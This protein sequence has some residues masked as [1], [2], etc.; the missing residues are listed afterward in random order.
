MT[1]NIQVSGKLP[2]GRI[3]V[4]GGDTADL[5]FDNLAGVL[6]DGEKAQR[7]IEDFQ[8]L[9]DPTI[10]QAVANVAPLRTGGAAAPTAA[11]VAAPGAPMCDH[12][13]RVR[14][15]GQGQ[16]GPWVGWFCPTPKGTVG[17]C[18]PEFEK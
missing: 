1:A 11:H 5:F 18:K 2:D 17:Q 14:R 10:G 7:V 6:G 3:F 15:E 9:V 13:A 4:V 8:I 12:G 16:R